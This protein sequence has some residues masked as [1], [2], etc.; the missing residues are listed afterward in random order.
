[1][2]FSCT[3]PLS[4]RA[5]DISLLVLVLCRY[6]ADANH[7]LQSGPD[8]GPTYAGNLIYYGGQVYVTGI[9]YGEFTS[10]PTGNAKMTSQCFLGCAA[11]DDS[12]TYQ[13]TKGSDDV[14]T[15][16][17]DL[18]V[19][20]DNSMLLIGSTEEGGV[21][22]DLRV[23]GSKK[24]E[25][26]GLLLEV[27]LTLD[28][29]NG[30]A[31]M[32]ESPVQYPRAM[33]TDGDHVYVAS[34]H[35]ENRNVNP[36]FPKNE[37]FVNLISEYK[38]GGNGEYSGYSLLLERFERSRTPPGGLAD[39]NVETTFEASWRKY[40]AI[41]PGSDGGA[42]PQL[43]VSDVL[44]FSNSL[45][46]VGFTDGRGEAFGEPDEVQ[47]G[48]VDGFV[49]QIELETGKIIK[50]NR[51]SGNGPLQENRLYEIC[52]TDD[53]IYM[54]GTTGDGTFAELSK[55][56]IYIEDNDTNDSNSWD[57][58]LKSTSAIENVKCAASSDGS[59]VYLAG[60][61][62]A[63]GTMEDYFSGDSSS[64]AGGDD[65]FVAQID[66]SNGELNWLKQ[67]G[68][69]G[70]ERMA[71][72]VVDDDGNAIL[73]GD[74]TG[75]MYRPGKSDN[76]QDLFLITVSKADGSYAPFVA[77]DA[78]TTPTQAPPTSPPVYIPSPSN[79]TI[80]PTK[81]VRQNGRHGFLIF[82]LFWSSVVGLL[83]LIRERRKQK[84]EQMARARVFA[85]ARNFDMED[86]DIRNSATGGWHGT[87]VG[88]LAHGIESR[89][90]SRRGSMQEVN[91]EMPSSTSMT[92]A[93]VVRDSLF[94]EDVSTTIAGRDGHDGEN[95]DVD[96]GGADS[97]LF[98]IDDDEDEDIIGAEGDGLHRE[99][100]SDESSSP[101]GK[102]IV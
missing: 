38:Y 48:R 69:S 64:P 65:V 32:H 72:L 4:W 92:H 17:T 98:S 1:M 57:K 16:C 100:Y 54:A 41:L 59:V 94:M 99:P 46:V 56:S 81:E 52:R 71:G 23:T 53:Q 93:S 3:F 10:N 97:A 8:V 35:S 90:G 33:A 45:I 58:R 89:G 95:D 70:E 62:T 68:T 80:T 75:S 50:N 18:E 101:W 21:L 24:A 47:S 83:Y 85:Y 74:T 36:D 6:F 66:A 73:Y 77:P 102:E 5:F 49:T 96:S 76:Y 20:S 31:L 79:P 19:L 9:T 14:D 7:S 42:I 28:L 15:I 27:A 67:I 86:I 88:L 84:E 25:Q 34:M 29:V 91:L 61:V 37:E 2:T 44:V 78:P 13:G 40:Y 60:T 43:H 22:T 63:E 55:I 11:A 39:Q 51:F 82:V 26:Y 12:W 87:Y 30:G